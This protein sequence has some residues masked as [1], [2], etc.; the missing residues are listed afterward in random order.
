MKQTTVNLNDTVAD[1]VCIMS[2]SLALMD[3][4]GSSYLYAPYIQTPIQKPD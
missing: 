4:S 2:C 1:D 3:T